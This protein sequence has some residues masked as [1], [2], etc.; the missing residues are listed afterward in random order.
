MYSIGAYIRLHVYQKVSYQNY[1]NLIVGILSSVLIIASV[2]ACFY[3]SAHYQTNIFINNV[4]YFA[5]Y[6]SIL[7]VIFAISWFLFFSNLNFHNRF[8]NF[9]AS[10]M[11]GVYLIHDNVFLRKIIWE[12]IYPNKLYLANPYLHCL[13]KVSLVFLICTLIDIIFRLTIFKF[14]KK[15][16]M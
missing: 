13:I 10:S 16:R 6:S 5:N 2:F 1:W 14:G 3:L 11:I 8:I 15:T 7:A 9:V 12:G 4:R